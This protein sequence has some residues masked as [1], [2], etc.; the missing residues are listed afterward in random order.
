MWLSIQ[1]LNQSQDNFDHRNKCLGKCQGNG[2]SPLRQL[3]LCLSKI[4]KYS[5]CIN[6]NQI[7]IKLTKLFQDFFLREKNPGIL[8]IGQSNLLP[9]L[10]LVAHVHFVMEK[11]LSEA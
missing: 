1:V 8:R 7:C 9:T 2:R 11:V 5:G 4:M 3:V 6:H 10:S